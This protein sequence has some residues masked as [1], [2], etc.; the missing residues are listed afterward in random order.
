MRNSGVRT[1][2]ILA[3]NIIIDEGIQPHV[4]SIMQH[5]EA[6][7]Q[8]DIQTTNGSPGTP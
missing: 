8:R 4:V 3:R 5:P 1:H 2:R 7:V 6:V